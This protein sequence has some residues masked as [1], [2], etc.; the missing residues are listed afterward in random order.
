MTLYQHFKGGL[1]IVTADKALEATN[2]NHQGDTRVNYVACINGVTFSR[3]FTEFHEN[4][5]YEGKTGP[6][7]RAIMDPADIMPNGGHP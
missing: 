3:E 1:Y 4:V 5:E 2:G 7:F 6:R